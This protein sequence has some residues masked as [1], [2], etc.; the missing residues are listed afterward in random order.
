MNHRL[1][2]TL[3]LIAV[4]L[5]GAL[6]AGCASPSSE[7]A[8]N[9]ADLAAADP[10]PLL[11]L[12]PEDAPTIG[13]ADV[14]TFDEAAGTI[15]RAT[16]FYDWSDVISIG[17]P[18][19]TWTI[20]F[21]KDW[22][23]WDL[24]IGNPSRGAGTKYTQLILPKNTTTGNTQISLDGANGSSSTVVDFKRVVDCPVSN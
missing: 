20:T 10:R 18:S 22:G 5:L 1:G 16:A 17:A 8:E 19:A 12:I 9:Q 2:F 24:Y 6:A 23:S 4:F 14:W 15:G 3:P 11:C 13:N 7:A 21:H